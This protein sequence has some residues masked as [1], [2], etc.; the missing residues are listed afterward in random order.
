MLTFSLGR[1]NPKLW[2]GSWHGSSGILVSLLSSERKRTLEE[3]KDTK[4]EKAECTML[5]FTI[6][7]IINFSFYCSP[8][9]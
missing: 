2:F 8:Y 9:S 4:I 3:M 5:G 1:C 6:Q 7:L